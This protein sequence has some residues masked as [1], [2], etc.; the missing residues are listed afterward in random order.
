M[1]V[2][3]KLMIVRGGANIS[4]AEV[5]I[6]LLEHPAVAV[7]GIPDERL[8][9]RVAAIV[10]PAPE[11]LP[12]GGGAAGGDRGGDALSDAALTAF[13]AAR[14]AR[15]KIPKVWAVASSLP[16]NAIRTGLLAILGSGARL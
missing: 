2:R 3:K 11:S 5:E 4:P 10:V 7:L 6:V 13:C 15:Y 1:V 12:A 8:G 16:V 9:E 14:L